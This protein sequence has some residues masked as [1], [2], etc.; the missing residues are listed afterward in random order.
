MNKVL[1]F[2]GAPESRA[3]DWNTPDLLV[4]FDASFLEIQTRHRPGPEQNLIPASAPTPAAWRCLSLEKERIP[5]GYTQQYDSSPEPQPDDFLTIASI[6]RS[7]DESSGDLESQFYEHSLAL[8]HSLTSVMSDEDHLD[9][10]SFL[11]ITNHVHIKEPLTLRGGDRLTDLKDIPSAAY[12]I[13]AQPQTIT[14]NLIVGIISISQPRTV[15]TRWGSDRFL[16]EVL[17]GDETKAGFAVTFWLPPGCD[18]VEGSMLQGLRNRD[19]VLLQNVALNV[20]AKKVYG[21][22]LP[23]RLTQ[24]HLLFRPRLDPTDVGG[25]YAPSDLSVTRTT[26]PQLDKT[27]RVWDWVLRFVGPGPITVAAPESARKSKNNKYAL[28]SAARPWDMPPPDTQ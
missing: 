9:T 24:V 11:D 26:H 19:V 16:V 27:R 13:K 5:T 8:H 21:S 7:F 4:D 25:H 6:S 12:L 18:T 20:F 23:K 3:L 28:P 17:V 1:I 10:A 2:T 14:C 22:S 15:G